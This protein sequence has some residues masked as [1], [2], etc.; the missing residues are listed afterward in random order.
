MYTQEQQHQ[1]AATILGIRFAARKLLGNVAYHESMECI[2]KTELTAEKEPDLRTKLAPFIAEIVA[3]PDLILRDEYTLD[4]RRKDWVSLCKKEV[5]KDGEVLPIDT[6]SR[7]GHKILDHWMP[8]FY[9]VRNWK[10]VSVRSLVTAAQLE[11]AFLTNIQ[12]HSTPYKS[13]IRR[14]L[15]M[16]GG[17]GNVTKYRAVTSKTIAE[18]FGARKVLDPCIGWG[19]RMIGALAAGAEYTGCEPDPNTFRGLR[20]ILGDIGK[21]ATILDQPAE[22]ALPGI[23]SGEFDLVLT[24]PPYFNLELYTAG[25]QS[26]TNHPSWDAWVETWLKP[27]ILSCLGKLRAGGT[28]CWSVKNFKTDRAYPL[29]DVTKKIHADAGWK[30]IKTVTMRGS[31][32][33]GGGRIVEGGEARGS[34]EDTF[35][36]QRPQSSC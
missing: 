3:N 27:V 11:K 24:S 8:H 12:M 9:D 4:Q 33:M 22:V 21:T 2:P 16:T 13:E 25:D 32:R 10:G 36:F 30:L 14:M 19:G 7:P 1:M 31:A 28:S 5:I 20:G 26:T 34:E 29:A 15:V 35:C 6:R 23:A 18:F 17:L